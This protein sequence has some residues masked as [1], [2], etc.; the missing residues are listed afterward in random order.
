MIVLIHAGTF[1]IAFNSL[2][3]I[4]SGNNSLVIKSAYSCVLQIKNR[5]IL[6]FPSEN[7]MDIATGTY[8]IPHLHVIITRYN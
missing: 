5:M 3:F 8:G 1:F 7:F 6:L 2:P 4:I